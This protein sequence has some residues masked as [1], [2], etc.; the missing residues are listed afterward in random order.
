MNILQ[1][2]NPQDFFTIGSFATLLGAT[3]IVYIVSGVIQ[4]VFNFSPK[5]LALVIS[6][7]ISLIGAS[8]SVKTPDVLEVIV[9]QDSI[10]IKYLIALLNG[11]LIFSSATGSNQLF[12]PKPP[13]LATEKG[14]PPLR[15]EPLA[16]RRRFRTLW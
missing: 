3:G 8:L 5:W 12:A 6:I 4:S 7:A 9:Q 2:V 13:V 16:I 11:C 14:V 15:P 10:W 1:V